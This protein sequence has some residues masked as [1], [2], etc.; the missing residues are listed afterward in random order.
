MWNADVIDI[1]Q[2][3][4]AIKLY[5][6]HV[7]LSFRQVLGLCQTSAGFSSFLTATFAGF[8]FDTGRQMP[9]HHCRF[10]LIAMLPS[11]AAAT[12]PPNLTLR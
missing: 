4:V 5:D 6:E 10:D 3:K 12:G 2:R 9:N 7:A 11:G 1:S 8:A